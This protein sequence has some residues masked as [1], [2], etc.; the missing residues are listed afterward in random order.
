MNDLLDELYNGIPGTTIL[1]S[2]LIPNEH[3]Q[4]NIDKINQQYR[5]L[6][7]KRHKA[8]DR[9]ILAE[10]DNGNITTADLSSDGIHPTDEGYRKMAAIWWSAF[11]S[12]YAQDM[13][14]AP[15]ALT[16]TSNSTTTATGTATATA[17][18]TATETGTSTATATKHSLGRRNYHVSLLS[19]LAIVFSV[20]FLVNSLA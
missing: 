7:A 3:A 8:G 20:L 1:F 18:G 12:A 19:M 14:Q 6:E 4:K 9:I 2:T 5:K 15:A 17:T 10:M 11:E 16:I 13:L